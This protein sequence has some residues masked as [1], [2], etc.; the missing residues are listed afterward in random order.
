MF[1]DNIVGKLIHWCP[2]FF[3]QVRRTHEQRNRLS[4]QRNECR[5][6][7]LISALRVNLNSG[8]TSRLPE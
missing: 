1:L 8:C 2:A 7:S 5:Q 4:Q 6:L 3:N